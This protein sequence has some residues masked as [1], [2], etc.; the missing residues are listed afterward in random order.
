[1][2]NKNILSRDVRGA[3]SKL[4]GGNTVKPRHFLVILINKRSI[5]YNNR[6]SKAPVIDG[7]R[8]LLRTNR[9]VIPG[10]VIQ[11]N[12]IDKKNSLTV[13][14]MLQNIPIFTLN[15]QGF[16][17]EFDPKTPHSHRRPNVT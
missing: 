15:S 11:V 7:A 16:L 13:P 10:T 17:I 14:N 3:S 2:S 5:K 6:R 9:L 12:F 1:M 4:A 8:K